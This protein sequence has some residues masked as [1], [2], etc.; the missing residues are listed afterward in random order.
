[1]NSHL[2]EARR[3][4]AIEIKALESLAQKLD[5][6]FD[7]AV[8][9]LY[10]CQGMVV[11]IGVGKSGLI[12]RKIAATLSSTGTPAF[13]LHAAE[14]SHGDLGMIRA[15]DVCLILSKSGETN[16]LLNLLPSIRRVG[17]RVLSLSG[18]RDST[19]SRESDVTL[20]VSVQ[21]E[22][23]PYDLAPTAS[24]VAMLAMGD[25][26]AIALLKRRNFSP[27]Q[28]ALLHPGGTLGRL[29]LL[30]VSD[31]MHKG[32]DCPTVLQNA[33]MTR[34]LEELIDKRLGAVCM[35]DQQGRLEGIITDG[36][37]KR[38]IFE[39]GDVRQLSAESLMTRNPITIA[40]DKLAQ[41]ALAV[42]ENRKTQI[43]VLPVVDEGNRLVGLLRIHDILRGEATRKS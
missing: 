33:D 4:F 37:L 21:Q 28:F 42:M 8:E 30:H 10:T 9:L 38:A 41:E 13:F 5:E 31:L 2:D 14:G 1:M 15:Q 39:H 18:R 40:P 26:L 25:A 19:L 20:D 17:S 29:L 43:S 34:V 27:Q 24:T 22:A 35:V 11:V 3:V 32:V 16:E 6:Q 12:G 36:D 7:R 23:C